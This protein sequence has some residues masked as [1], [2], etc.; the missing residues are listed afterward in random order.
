MPLILL[1]Q[2]AGAEC[3]IPRL[4]DCWRAHK[5]GPINPTLLHLI[6]S[7]CYCLVSAMQTLVYIPYLESCGLK[8]N[9]TGDGITSLSAPY[10][11]VLSPSTFFPRNTAD[12]SQHYG[13]DKCKKH[14]HA[15]STC[16]TTF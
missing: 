4:T 5:L 14:K 7:A 9:P 15:T 6:T 10:K 11:T 8:Q 16:T 13:H 2:A 3:S 12:L 1:T